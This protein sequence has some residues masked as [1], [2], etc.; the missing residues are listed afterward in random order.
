MT[1]TTLYP[2][3]PADVPPDLTRPDA[4]YRGRVAAMIGGLFI[5]L[6]LYLVF[7]KFFNLNKGSN[8][9]HFPVYLLTSIML[10]TFFVAVTRSFEFAA[11][12]AKLLLIPKFV[13]WDAETSA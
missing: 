11:S 5:F 8:V 4:A 2:P 10:W 7:V 13:D 12:T 6:V 1:D 9:H 3:R